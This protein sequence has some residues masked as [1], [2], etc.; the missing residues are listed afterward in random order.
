MY[1]T[2][3]HDKANTTGPG[4]LRIGHGSEISRCLESVLVQIGLSGSAR[5]IITVNYFI[6]RIK[7]IL[8]K[9]FI[10]QIKADSA[11]GL[12][13]SSKINSCPIVS[14]E[15]AGAWAL[16]SL[17]SEADLQRNSRLSNNKAATALSSV[18][19]SMLI[20]QRL[21]YSFPEWQHGWSA[22]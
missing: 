7:E 22:K 5:V 1:R 18:N 19:L 8:S 9:T 21:Q 2:Q 13:F 20:S 6:I 15:P 3:T 4:S 14:T 12:E 11:L 10:L 16:K 17:N